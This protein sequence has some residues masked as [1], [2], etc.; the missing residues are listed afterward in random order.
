MNA[1]TEAI[2]RATQRMAK[3][4]FWSTVFV[5][6]GTVL[7]IWTLWLTRQA[8]KAARDAVSVTR[9]IGKKQLRAYLVLE[10]MPE[11]VGGFSGH[12]LGGVNLGMRISNRGQTPAKLV[13]ATAVLQHL[14]EVESGYDP[15]SFAKPVDMAAYQCAPGIPVSTRIGQIPLAKV[16]SLITSKA[17]TVSYLRV[18]YLD[19][20]GDPQHVE[21]AFQHQIIILPKEGDALSLANS[22]GTLNYPLGNSAS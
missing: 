16:Q 22:T 4:A 9:E 7:L 3:Y 15:S 14:D 21:A 2:N 20:F 5:G 19:A 11:W 12:P 17:Q 10:S 6:V 1:A 8:N 18:D 13:K